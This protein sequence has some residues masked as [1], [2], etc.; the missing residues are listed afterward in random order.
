MK[1]LPK[2]RKVKQYGTLYR[3]E[4][5]GKRSGKK[6]EKQKRL[7][8][9]EAFSVLESMFELILYPAKSEHFNDEIR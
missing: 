7:H 8:Q 6:Q 5:Y 4:G 1:Q 2:V 9:S 3:M